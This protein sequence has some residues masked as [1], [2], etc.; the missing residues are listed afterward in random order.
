MARISVD[1]PDGLKDEIK[2]TA[3]RKN[4]K[5]PSEYIRQALR[6]KL[7]EDSELDQ[8][9]LLRALKLKQGDVE[10]TSIDDIIEKYE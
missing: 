3:E 1:V 8:E 9:L 6:E 5:S 7:E 4:F 10:T 2:E